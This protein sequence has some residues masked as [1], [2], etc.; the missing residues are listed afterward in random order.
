MSFDEAADRRLT[1]FVGRYH[2]TN[3]PVPRAPFGDILGKHRAEAIHSIG[4]CSRIWKRRAGPRA[5]IFTCSTNPTTR[6]PTS[7]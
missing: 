4:R 1:E 5:R 6:R 3:V 7:A 2:V